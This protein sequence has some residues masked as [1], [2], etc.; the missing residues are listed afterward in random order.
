M[1]RE[2]LR[3]GTAGVTTVVWLLFTAIQLAG[4]RLEPCSRFT[5]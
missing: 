3:L 1:A 5:G 2:V 4:P